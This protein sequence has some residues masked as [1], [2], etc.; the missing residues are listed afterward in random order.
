MNRDVAAELGTR[1]SSSDGWKVSV[2]SAD[3]VDTVDAFRPAMSCLHNNAA[4][5]PALVG[6]EAKKSR[7]HR[8]AAA[9]HTSSDS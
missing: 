2:D 1:P 8:H 6:C 3:G 7:K 4:V 9:V 5:L